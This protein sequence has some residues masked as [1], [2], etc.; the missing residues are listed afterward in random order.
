MVSKPAPS[1]ELRPQPPDSVSKD[2]ATALFLSHFSTAKLV[3]PFRDENSRWPNSQEIGTYRGLCWKNLV[4][5]GF[6]EITRSKFVSSTPMAPCFLVF[7]FSE[8][9]VFVQYNVDF[10]GIGGAERIEG[11]I[12]TI[13]ENGT[14][15]CSYRFVEK[16]KTIWDSKLPKVV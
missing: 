10:P 8:S 1:M 11:G 5:P 9:I 15:F 3:N 12:E 13:S 4:W 7:F 6:R 14:V 2:F 16:L